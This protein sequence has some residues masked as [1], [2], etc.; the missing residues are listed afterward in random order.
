MIEKIIVCY[1]KV[2]ARTHLRSVPR[3]LRVAI[4]SLA[5]PVIVGPLALTTSAAGSPGKTATFAQLVDTPPSYIFPL[6]SGTQSGNNNITYVI[7]LMWRPLYWYGHT[8]SAA[9]T[10]NYQK[11]LALPPVYSNGGRT[12]TITLKSYRWSDGTPVTTRDVEFWINLLLADKADWSASAPG[13]WT[14]HLVKAS[15]PSAKTFS[16]TFNVAFNQYWFLY[17]E[18]CQ[19]TPIPQHAWDRTSAA[20]PVGNYD[21]TTSGAQAVYNFLNSESEDG[22]TWDTDPLWQSVDGPWRVEP[23][24]GYDPTTGRIALVPNDNYS[25]GPKPRIAKLVEL[26]FTSAQ[27]ELNALLAGEV[28]YGYLPYNDLPEAKTLEQRG[29]RIDPWQYWGYSSLEINFA[30]PSVGPALKQLYVRRALQHLIDQPEFIKKVFGGYGYPTTGP[31]PSQPVSDFVSPQERSVPYPYSVST[32]R[33]LLSSHGWNLSHSGGASCE[34][35]GVGSS[36][37]GPGVLGGAVLSFSLLYPTGTPAYVEQMESLSSSFSEA[38]IDLKVR[39]EPT[40]FIFSNTFSCNPQTGSGC[41]WQMFYLG[42]PSITYLP[43]VYPSG[44][45]VFASGAPFNPGNYSSAHLNSLIVATRFGKGLQPLYANENYTAEQL[46]VLWMPNSDY[47]LSVIRKTLKGVGVQDSLNHI[48]PEDWY[49]S[50]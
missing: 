37:C 38:G 9:P 22:S 20:G 31:V 7:P 3:P 12:V 19:M 34:R 13:D 40:S 36:D 10:V 17:N 30:N 48:Y 15:Y 21:M 18:L 11:S 33:S 16:L 35:P 24:S 5:I 4:L 14:A 1:R 47:Q 29:F 32:A 2:C 41:S 44:E 23:G 50:S 42:A 39:G 27:A 26:P 49:F 43:G 46:P 6:F 45:G 28:D 8:N 25:G